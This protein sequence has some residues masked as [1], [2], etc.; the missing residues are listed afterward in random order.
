M[1][2]VRYLKVLASGIA[3]T[4]SIVKLYSFENLFEPRL[5]FNDILEHPLNKIFICSSFRYSL[6]YLRTI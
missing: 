5:I 3:L 2:L 4:N 6:I 1:I